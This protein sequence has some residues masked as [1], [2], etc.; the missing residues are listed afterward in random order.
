MNENSSRRQ[1]LK[2]AATVAVAAAAHRVAGA[3]EH[4][5]K[6]GKTF[7]YV[8]TYTG[9]LGK[10]KNGEGIYRFELDPH[11]GDLLHGTLVARTPSPS[12]ITIHPSKRYLYAINEVENFEG[13]NGSVSA[14]AID[15]GSGALCL[16]NTVSSAGAG[17]AYMSVDARG[18]FAFV[19]NYIGGS[20]AVLPIR[21]DGSLGSA[22]CVHHDTG[23]IGA[24][25]ATNAPAG[26]FAISG[27][28][29]PHAHMIHADPNNR[30]V[31]STDLGQDRIYSYRLQEE[32]GKL[33]PV[34]ATPFFKLP[35]GDGPRH[36]AFH[37]NKR[38]M[39]SIQE[40]AS[41]I[42][43]FHYAPDSGILDRQQIISALPRGFVGTNFSSEIA[44]SAQGNVLYAANR[45]HNTISV[46][47][48]GT[49]GRLAF[50]GENSTMGDYPRNFCIDPTGRFLFACN[51]LSD[52]IV[53]F[54]IHE[55]DGS[56]KFSG[57]YT[58]V[59]T[60]ACITFLS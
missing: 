13:N 34:A 1:F 60:P 27:H 37:P 20:I 32:T 31:L 51:Q 46:F 28:D 6:S 43:F 52:N 29:A 23:A 50:A 44:I 36:F 48:I 49:D 22:V 10:Q 55:S 38:W 57:N 39:Y 7:A 18:K 59:P 3:T 5:S 25:R 4:I 14:F 45:L 24:Q 47:K 16:I 15:R 11:N 26:S 33:T 19:A 40:E 17:P 41:T 21:A 8:G 54:H 53:R 12:W 30:F 9:D 35:T 2:S 42:A 58:A 56:L